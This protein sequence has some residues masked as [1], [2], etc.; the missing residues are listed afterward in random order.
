MDG[1]LMI[2]LEV[3]TQRVA[4]PELEGDTPRTVDVDRVSNRAIAMKS[5]KIEPRNIHV[6]WSPGP[7]KSVE[8]T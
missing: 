8:T 3:D 5:M 1:L 4:I 6:P 7:I 2:L